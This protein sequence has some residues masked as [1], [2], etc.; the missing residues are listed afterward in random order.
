MLNILCDNCKSSLSFN[1][2]SCPKCNYPT[3]KNQRKCNSCN[4]VLNHAQ[5]KYKAYSN[6]VYNG[7]T[8]SSSY[9]V[10]IPCTNCGDPEPLS[11]TIQEFFKK[12]LSFVLSTIVLIIAVILFFGAKSAYHSFF[13]K[14]ENVTAEPPIKNNK[15]KKSINKSNTHF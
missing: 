7:N 3:P 5:H 8:S 2:L 13:D 11:M 14:K 9:T 6:S 10:H 12:V 1:A 4:T 15:A